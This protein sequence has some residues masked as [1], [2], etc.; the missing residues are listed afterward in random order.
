MLGE[1]NEAIKS[2]KIRWGNISEDTQDKD[3]FEQQKPTAVAWKVTDLDDLLN[4]FN[5]LRG[6]C[7]QI[8]WGWINERWL[9]TMHLKDQN[10]DWD[11]SIIKLMQ[12]RPDSKDAVGLDHID[13]WSKV[14]N[15]AKSILEKTNLKWTEEKNTTHC[16][17]VSIW[18]DQTEA[19]LRTDTVLDP[20]I[21]ELKETKDKILEFS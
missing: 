7:D 8:H 5:T 1:I 21:A 18:F 16:K 9:I 17:W 2:Y 19:K 20:C 15:Q 13:F 3:F 4:K 6:L 12:R 11:I 10:L 14:N